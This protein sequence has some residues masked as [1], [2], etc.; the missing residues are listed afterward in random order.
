MG[1]F[2]TTN[3]SAFKGSNKAARDNEDGFINT[4][5]NSLVDDPHVNEEAEESMALFKKTQHLIAQHKFAMLRIRGLKIDYKAPDG[6]EKFCRV[7]VLCETEQ[8]IL[9]FLELVKMLKGELSLTYVRIM[10]NRQINTGVGHQIPITEKG[11]QAL[12]GA[13]ND[14]TFYMVN[15]LRIY[16]FNPEVTPLIAFASSLSMNPTLNTIGFA[17]NELTMDT[18][19]A[20]LQHIYNNP[21]L[22]T[23]DLNGNPFSGI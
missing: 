19:A 1:C 23:I 16:Q 9:S 18:C 4:N 6:K 13:L 7:E 22:K 8:G 10:G 17:K 15:E 12:M 21:S 14:G 2:A 20:I 11:F 3:K 5:F